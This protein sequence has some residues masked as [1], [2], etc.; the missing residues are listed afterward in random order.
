MTKKMS[1]EWRSSVGISIYKNKGDVKS[2]INYLKI[3]LMSHTIKL[4][5]RVIEL[6]EKIN[7]VSC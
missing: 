7:L 3:E 5:E 2:F 4:F 1:D 6:I